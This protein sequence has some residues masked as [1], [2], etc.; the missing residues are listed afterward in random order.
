MKSKSIEDRI[1]LNNGIEIPQFGLGV[2]LAKDGKEVYKAVAHA[3]QAG[4]RLIDT[5]AIYKNEPSVG[6]AIRESNIA[7]EDIFLTT[8]LWNSRQ[9]DYKQVAKGFNDSLQRLGLEYVDLYLVHWAVKGKY[10]DSWK[11]MEE[12]YLEGKIKSIGV[13]NFQVHHLESILEK[14]QIVP[15]VNQVELHPF[16]Q[17]RQLLNF[18]NQHHILV[19]AWRPILKGEADKVAELVEIGKKYNKSGVQVTLR[20][21]LQSGII[22]IPKSVNPDRITHNADLFDFELSHEDMDIISSLNQDKRFGPDPDN[23]DF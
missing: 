4:Y 11:A 2:F 13:S 10:E 16:L 1:A 22:T 8:K 5:A 3:L 18:C 17:Q 21:N 9:G 12:L 19:E 7:R 14:S 6:K 15:A 20:W 23:F